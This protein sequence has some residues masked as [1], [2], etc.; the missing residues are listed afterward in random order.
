[1]SLPRRLFSWW[2]RPRTASRRKPDGRPPRPQWW[3]RLSVHQNTFFRT[4]LERLLPTLQLA[5][6]TGVGLWGDKLVDW[7]TQELVRE[8]LSSGLNVS[9]VGVI[10]GFTRH[11]G[12]P[13]DEAIRDGFDRIALAQAVRASCVR[14]ISGPTGLH[15]NKHARRLLIHGLR[16]LLPAAQAAGVRLALQPMTAKESH[17]TFL[18][19]L[20]AADAILDEVAH[21]ALSLAL[22]PVHIPVTDSMLPRLERL[23]PWIAMVQLTDQRT[24]SQRYQQELP[25]S[26]ELPLVHSIQAL[27]SMGYQGWYELEVWS[28][29]LWNLDSEILMEKCQES[30][31]CLVPAKTPVD[32]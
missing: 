10:G 23:V 22:N 14:V 20:E 5:G 11:N 31:G 9:S 2:G 32:A 4:P 27:E 18:H 7:T 16:E 28:R 1:M 21:P 25:G 17:W 12:Y 15:L 13:L 26:G 3:S 24:G 30:L 8:L 19:S 29:D 6:I